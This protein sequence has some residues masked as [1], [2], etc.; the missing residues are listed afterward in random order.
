VIVLAPVAFQPVDWYDLTGY[1]DLVHRE[2]T[3]RE[4]EFLQQVF[5]RYVQ[6]G[7]RR[8]LEPAC[9]SGRLVQA[10]ARRGFL[11]DGFDCNQKMLEAA[12]RKTQ[13][14]AERVKLYRAVL[15]DF[16]ARP[17]YDLAFCMISTFRHLLTE[18]SARRHLELVRDSLKPG[19]VYLLGL[20]LSEYGV[21]AKSR[22]RWTGGRGETRVV[23]N[24]QSWPPD[25][26][27]RLE[28]NR[29]RVIVT[30]NGSVERFEHHFILRSYSPAQLRRLLK[31]IPGFFHVATYDFENDITTPRSLSDDRLDFILVLRKE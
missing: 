22:E 10:M 6:S 3:P 12:R 20:H 27:N 4:A 5:E 8:L 29:L 2:D 17:L 15:D 14:F 30:R 11:V 23:C 9:G 19:G 28:K 26:R 16:P 18:F 21:D 25:Q 7:G 13:R 1:Y 31:S 24:L